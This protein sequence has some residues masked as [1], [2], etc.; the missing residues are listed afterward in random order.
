MNNPKLVTII[1]G[2]IFFLLLGILIF[3]VL[4]YRK[5]SR[6]KKILSLDVMRNE[7]L[8]IPIQKEIDASYELAKGEQL[9]EKIKNYQEIYNNLK[10]V[11]FK[12]IDDMINELDMMVETNKTK[13]FPEK[14]TLI[15]IEL[16]KNRYLINHM[17]DELKEL[18][19]YE[20]K[21]RGI[22]I[23][24]KNKYRILERE[25]DNNKELY[26]VIVD[27][28]KMQFENIEKRFSDFELV[29]DEN[30]YNE[31][32]LVVHSLDGMINHI[33]AIILEL[34]DILVLV[35]DLIP[36]RLKE[37]EVLRSSMTNDGY[38]LNFM[39]LDYNVKEI[40][41]IEN[42]IIDRSKVLNINNS[43]IELK[44]ILQF[45]DSLFKDIEKEKVYKKDFDTTSTSFNERM[46]TVKQS[47][48][49]MNSQL[50]D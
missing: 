48:S 3:F 10:N 20:D 49:D 9:E 16:F 37:L 31:V 21:Y 1:I 40:E 42:D 35:N 23:K 7:I 12:E 38:M 15:E 45:L 44:T 43:L 17:I 6:R 11:S 28:I 5:N 39:K 8:S 47:L 33:G 26:G 30:L 34:P 41:R 46:S 18:T 50:D 2:I 19:S 25:F 14:C 29:I 32:V 13:E 36:A 4:K 27:T 22:V 24:L